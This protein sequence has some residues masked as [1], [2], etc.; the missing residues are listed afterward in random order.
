[1][2]LTL[3]AQLVAAQAHAER[4]RQEDPRR[5]LTPK[6]KCVLDA[7]RTA[8]KPCTTQQLAELTQLKQRAV[9]LALY[10][11]EERDRVKRG[12]LRRGPTLHNLWTA[13]DDAE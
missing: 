1:M 3:Y 11:L 13:L 2:T 4:L 7:L 12:Q 10:D 9:L 5:R 6:Q 8:G